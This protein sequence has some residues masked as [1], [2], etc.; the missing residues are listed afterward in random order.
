MNKKNQKK[1]GLGFK[2]VIVLFLIVVAASTLLT[3]GIFPKLTNSVPPNQ[4]QE[5]IPITPAPGEINQSNDSLQLKTITFKG[6]SGTVTVDFLLDRSGSMGD[7]T[8]TGETKISRLKQAVLDLTGKLD[9]TS[10][11]GIQSFS[12]RS[13]TNDV[14]VSYYKDVKSIIPNKVNALQASGSTPTH[15]A[16]AYSYA[17]LQN[18]LPKFSNRKFNFILIS[19]GKPVPD[20]QDPRLFNPNPADQIKALGVNVFTL[21]VYDSGQAND[22]KLRDLLKSI[23]SK[24]EN[25]YEAQNADQVTGLLQSISTKLCESPATPTPTSLPVV[26][27]GNPIVNNPP[28]SNPPPAPPLPP[29]GICQGTARYCSCQTNTT[30]G[31]RITCP[32]ALRQQTPQY[33]LD[34]LN[35]RDSTCVMT[36]ALTARGCTDSCYD[37]PVIYLYPEK[38]TY[39]SIKIKTTGKVVVSDPLYPEETGW[40]NILALPGGSLIYKNKVYSELFYETNVNSV[41]TP[42]NGVVVESI[43]IKHTLYDLTNKL[44]LIKPEQDELVDYWLPR[45]NGLNKKYILISL[46]DKET[47]EKTDKVIINPLPDTRI[48]FILYFKGLDTKLNVLGLALPPTPKRIG[49]T[50]VE[51]GGTIATE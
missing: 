49:F 15:D 51:W 3:G 46:I 21:A 37:K 9:D 13:I 44:G 11:I 14:P 35:A 28:V 50:E 36:P 5:Y 27:P 17:V 16:L 29:S 10:V 6:C 34:T 18:A 20:S 12:S 47:K 23:A 24:P 4:G 19:D 25:Y 1:R 45:L 33:C 8:P 48:E 43:N 2:I 40:E 38:P 7:R 32:D 30:D 41:K 26:N 39:V 22:P 42:K 31:H